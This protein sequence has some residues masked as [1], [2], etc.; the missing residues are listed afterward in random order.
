[1]GEITHSYDVAMV[2]VF[3]KAIKIITKTDMK[4]GRG[5]FGDYE[6]SWRGANKGIDIVIF[7][8]MHTLNS[9]KFGKN[10]ICL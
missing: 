5:M 4:F 9:Q 3:F 6:G 1:M 2:M 10:L 7:P 8:S